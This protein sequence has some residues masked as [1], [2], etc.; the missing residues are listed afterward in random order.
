[1]KRAWVLGAT[2]ALGAWGWGG[3]L[4][5]PKVTLQG[6][7]AVGATSA[8]AGAP[9]TEAGNPSAAR[10][11]EREARV[12]TPYTVATEGAEG[13]TLAMKSYRR[14]CSGGAY[15]R[16]LLTVRNASGAAIALDRVYAMEGFAPK[17]A[18]GTLAKS[19]N[20]D[21]AVM[22]FTPQTG[23]GREWWAVEHPMAR[24]Q[25]QSP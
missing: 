18:S 10:L 14:A 4:P 7:A 20:T 9:V 6:G 3:A 5:L 16:T 2:F 21:G 23:E 11:S 24:Y 19:G 1:M 8:T 12:M 13:L 22:V 25:W 15:T 17:G